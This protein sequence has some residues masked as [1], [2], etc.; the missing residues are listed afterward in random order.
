MMTN[1]KTD[2]TQ[3]GFTIIELLIATSV[4]SLVLL[5]ALGSFLQIG[6]LFY[7]GVSLTSVQNVATQTLNDMAGNLQVATDY[8]GQQTSGGYYYFCIDGT[9]YTYT[10]HTYN[11][12]QVSSVANSSASPF[13]YSPGSNDFGLL[14]D[15]PGGCSAPCGISCGPTGFDKTKPV[16]MLGDQMRL[17]NI[18]ITTSATNLYNIKLVVA[19]G[20]DSVLSFSTGPP[21]SASCLGNSANQAFCSVVS[22]STA[23]VKGSQT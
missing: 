23:V 6:R 20:A 15:S 8:T 3:K 13:S 9:R 1:R 7:K 2:S 17:V 16:E 12:Q 21:P 5:V 14:K 11:S 10:T 18:T 19:Y 4:F 22:T